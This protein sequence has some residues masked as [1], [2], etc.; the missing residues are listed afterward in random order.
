MFLFLSKLLPLF[1]YPLGLAS[2]LLVAALVVRRPRWQRGLAAAALALL[3]LFSN[4]PVAHLL[5]R[6]LEWRYLPAGELPQAEAIVLLGGGTRP[7]LPPRPASEMNEAGDR[8]V[9]A[10]QLYQAGKA[11]LVVVSGGFIEFLGSTVP[12]AEAMQQLLE[13][14]GVPGEAILQEDR[15]RNTYENAVFVRELLDER[16]IRRILLVTSALH[17][18]RSVSIFERQGF[19]VIPAPADFLVTW[20]PEGQG[21]DV[22][23]GGRLLALLPSAESLELSTRALK[24]YIGTVVYRL[25][26]W[27]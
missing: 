20:T 1:I 7:A 24:E 8:M 12:E 26:G 17:M 6:S 18:P 2:L 21:A 25:R 9:Y 14:L 5:V 15:S 16:G 22:G 11:P 3:L 23:V 19:E 27:L 4:Q 10:A 13:R